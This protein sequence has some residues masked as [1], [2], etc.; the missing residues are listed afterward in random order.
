MIH[1][2]AAPLLPEGAAVSTPALA[3][4]A[5]AAAEPFKTAA[6]CRGITTETGDRW[7]RS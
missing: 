5:F 7:Y 1:W 6:A 2:P 3:A 4:P